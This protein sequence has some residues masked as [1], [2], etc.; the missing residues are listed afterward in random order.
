MSMQIN[1]VRE[2]LGDLPSEMPNFLSDATIRRFLRARNWSTVQAAKSLKEAARWRRQYEPQ[3]IHWEN[4]ANSENEAKRAYIPDYLDNNGRMVF[5]TLPTIKTKTSEE[6][7]IKYFVYNLENL[8][9]SSEDAQEENVVWMSD[10]RGWTI[11]STPFSLTRESLH[12]VQKY[13]PGLIAVAI[14]T[15]APRIFESFWKIVKHF[16]EPKMNEKVKFVY[17][18]SAE[19]RRIMSDMFD[20][21]KLESI[22][23]GRNT[24]GLDMNKYADKM[25][26]RDLIRGASTY[27]NSN[28]SSSCS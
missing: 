26:T 20:L 7:Y 10:L 22:F 4:I 9:L 15:N 28:A 21:D 1:E 6:E 5:V 8:A 14:M 17:S 11:S 23:G 19:S 18:N 24:A 12:I 2:L 16:L 27:A 13:Y 3:K 25:R